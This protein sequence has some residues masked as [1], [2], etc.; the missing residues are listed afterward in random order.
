MYV[1]R[2]HHAWVFLF[3]SVLASLTACQPATVIP[4]PPTPT[5]TVAPPPTLIR[6][7]YLQSVTA[8][9]I[10]VAWETDRASHGEVVYGETEE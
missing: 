7:P 8:A 6:G 4:A 5:C 10:I 1:K 9:S 3:L 2:N